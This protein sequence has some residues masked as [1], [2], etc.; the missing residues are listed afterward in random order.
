MN[1]NKN[2]VLVIGKLSKFTFHH[3]VHG[4]EFYSASLEMERLSETRDIIPIMATKAKANGEYDGKTVKIL[5]E[6]RSRD[7]DNEGKNKLSLY[8]HTRDIEIVD[9]GNANEIF[10]DGYICKKP[11]YR[12]TPLGRE[13]TDIILAVNR[14][15]G[16]SDYIPCITWGKNA[17]YAT[18][19]KV[20]DRIQIWGRVQSRKY[21]KKTDDEGDLE[22]TAYEVSV[23]KVEE[24]IKGE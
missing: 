17:R 20:G 13:I 7:L 6:F 12:K 2:E 11:T 3:R 14:P 5:G 18:G 1:E 21:T 24:V 16:K 4:I 22:M 15:Y 23:K 10:M 19:F 8:V 9:D